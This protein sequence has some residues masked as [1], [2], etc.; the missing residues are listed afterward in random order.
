MDV[1]I[2]PVA[3]SKIQQSSYTEDPLEYL[4][5]IITHSQDAIFSKTLDGTITSWNP[6]AERMYGYKAEEIIGKSIVTIVPTELRKDLKGIFSKLRKGIPIEH[7][8]TIRMRKDG[9]RLFVSLSISPIKNIEEK[10]IGASVIARNISEQKQAA[11]DEQFM[12]EA[13]T[14]L[15]SSLDYNKTLQSIAKLAVPNLADWCAI[16]LIN[17]KGEIE[18]VSIAHVDPEKVKWAREL[19]R[20][21][22]VDMSQPTGLPKVLRTGKSEFYPYISDEIIKLSNP[23]PEQLK[24]IKQIGFRSVI[25]VPLIIRGKTL[26]GITF[27]S[28]NDNNLYNKRRL[29]LAEDLAKRAS[30]AIDNA[31]LFRQVQKDLEERKKIES[32]LRVS[33]MRFKKLIDSNIIGVI[34]AKFDGSIIEANKFFLDML[35]Y[36]QKELK[37]GKIRWD[38]LTPEKW[39]H[40]DAKAIEEL[41]VFGVANPWEK[42]YIHKNGTPIP[43]LVGCTVLDEEAETVLTF[44]LDISERKEIE[45]RKDDFIS[46]ASHELKTPVTS[47]KVFTQLLAKRFEKQS[48]TGTLSL[49]NK[50]DTQLNKL[51]VLI[52]DLLDVS[53]IHSGKLALRPEEFDIA[54][55]IQETKEGLEQTTKHKIIFKNNTPLNVIA[56]RER[57]GQ[58]ITNFLTNAIKYSPDDKKIVITV[59]KNK[60]EVQFGVRDFGMGISK[61][62][63]ARIFDR[64]YQAKSSAENTFPGLGMGLYISSEIIRRHNG[65]LWV[66][67]KMG[68]GSHFFFTIPLQISINEGK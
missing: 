29:A 18:L 47:M 45:Q 12:A 39:F 63:Q 6:A 4:A 24:I 56:D 64:F 1:F 48:D 52:S 22:P 61:E 37:T 17:G 55:L 51:I 27:V 44:V 62:D 38:E 32:A 7:Y 42:E 66:E 65:K 41:K 49:I 40:L 68:S 36:S 67:S 33:E 26:G 50:M 2:Q 20:K 15:A 13:S 19:R 5:A 53:R 10:I 11:I 58:V 43:V 3:S 30:Q 9:T 60:T 14:L 54:S 25:I 28:T 23:T 21:N 46:I 8:E 34:V 16:D 31:L 57:I 35:G 59:E